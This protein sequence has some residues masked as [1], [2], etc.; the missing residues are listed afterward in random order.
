MRPIAALGAGLL[1]DRFNVSRMTM[2]AF[3]ILLI[4]DLFFAM[5]TP[6]LG[7][8]SILLGNTLLGAAAF[9][10]LRGLYFALFEEARVPAAMT[11]T[12]VGFVSLI[13]YTPDIFVNFVAGVL[14]DRSPG[15]TGHQHFFWFL[16]GFAFV[17]VVASF[18]LM[19]LLHSAEQKLVPT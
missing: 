11:G 9:F 18:C 14:I 13:G 3:I 7:T 8:A 16:S 1:G 2:T 15:L 10:A 6:I 19:R 4:S 17:G 5:T 12:A